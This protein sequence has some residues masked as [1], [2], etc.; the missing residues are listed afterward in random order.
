ME[1]LLW[2]VK[3][4]IEWPLIITMTSLW[5]RWRLKSASWLFTQPFIQTQIKK[6]SKLPVTGPLCVEFTGHFTFYFYTKTSDGEL[7]YFFDLRLNK[8]F[9]LKNVIKW[10]GIPQL[11]LTRKSELCRNMAYGQR[12]FYYQTYESTGYP[13]T[14]LLTR[15]YLINDW[16]N[17]SISI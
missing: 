9:P 10:I 12:L 5:A 16:T 14:L 11:Y 13:P 4:Y 7:C 3:T 2:L 15:F 8:L 6:T 17:D 1:R